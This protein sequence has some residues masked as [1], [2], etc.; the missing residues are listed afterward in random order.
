MLFWTNEKTN[1]A[2]PSKIVCQM[3]SAKIRERNPRLAR[4]TV[5]VIIKLV[6]VVPIHTP[7]PSAVEG[8]TLILKG[9]EV[10]RCKGHE[11]FEIRVGFGARLEVLEH[12]PKVLRPRRQQR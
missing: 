2:K 3:V 9:V 8:R 10:L 7:P 11:L 1:G 4:A 6:Q 5:M 12:P